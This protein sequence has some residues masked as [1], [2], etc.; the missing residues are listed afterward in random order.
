[1]ALRNHYATSIVPI[2]HR[3]VTDLLGFLG[4][5]AWIVSVVGPIP[6]GLIA[7]KIADR[8]RYGWA[9]H[10]AFLPALLAAHWFLA[11]FIFYAAGDTGDGP[12]GLGFAMLPAAASTLITIAGYYI[13]LFG[14]AVRHRFFP[15]PIQL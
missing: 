13:W 10:I 5:V 7:M 14:T 3:G 12:P 9:V 1:M 2:V 15:G 6:L 4:V 11:G 8:T